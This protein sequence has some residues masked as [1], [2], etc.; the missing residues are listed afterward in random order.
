MSLPPP[1]TALGARLVRGMLAEHIPPIW[2]KA[3]VQ[4]ERGRQWLMPRQQ[5]AFIS[6]GVVLVLLLLIFSGVTAAVAAVAAWIALMRHFAQTDAD[7]QRRI[8]ESY[9]KAVEQL[10]HERIEV[11]LGGIYTLERIFRESPTDYWIVLETLA[12]FVRERAPGERADSGQSSDERLA[13]PRTDIAAAI[14]VIL[15]RPE[16][17][18]RREAIEE[19]RLNLSGADLRGANL[20]NAHL[21]G[22][23]LSFAR[24]DRTDL[25]QA[26]LGA[27]NFSRA[28]LEGADLSQAYLNS[29]FLNE[30][31]LQRADLTNTHLEGAYLTGAHLE[32]ADVR[33]ANLLHADVT[34]THLEGTD[35]SYARLRGVD[36]GVA[37]GD[38]K[39][40]LPDNFPRP[41]NWPPYEL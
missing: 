14:T 11:R 37:L 36:L 23:N 12:A 7:R 18:R 33:E 38:A 6:A 16:E 32:G 13:G 4:A 35:L 9:S 8:T 10:A 5:A 1:R 30:A 2:K 39:T 28:R 40:K 17:M 21:E 26:Y 41:P 19:W 3:T 25:R 15:R 20:S 31:H 27:A 34:D 22:A 29:A 24:L